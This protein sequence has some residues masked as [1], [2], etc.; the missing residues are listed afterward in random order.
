MRTV[1]VHLID[2]NEEDVAATLNA[3]YPAQ[4]G[5]DWVELVD[6]DACL[7]IHFYYDLE[8]ESQPD[9][10][11]R[12][13]AHLGRLPSVSVA[14]DVSGRHTGKAQVYRF[15]ETLLERWTGVAW[16]EFSDTLWTLAQVRSGTNGLL[17][18]DDLGYPT[19]CL[20]SCRR[21][22]ER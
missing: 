7:Y 3:A 21:H 11:E 13:R 16:D 15:V 8:L 18:F 2:C 12:L 20:H 1:I 14:A 19:P 5:P 22:S 6:G 17:F 9:D 10:I 4:P